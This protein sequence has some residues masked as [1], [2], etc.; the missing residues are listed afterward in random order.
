LHFDITFAHVDGT[1]F[2]PF[3]LPG[4]KLGL[5]LDNCTL[6]FHDVSWK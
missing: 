5:C 3:D 4:K 6:T 2:G 1:D